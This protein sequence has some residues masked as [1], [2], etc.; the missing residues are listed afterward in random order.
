MVENLEE[1][2]DWDPS[3]LPFINHMIAGSLA[4]LAEHVTVFPIDTL[5]THVQCEVCGATDA[6]QVW[7]C[8]SRIVRH[9]GIFRLWRGVSAMFAACIPAHAAYFS[10]YESS[11]KLLMVNDPSIGPQHQPLRAALCGCFASISHDLFMTPFGKH[12]VYICEV[13]VAYDWIS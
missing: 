2:E 7:N 5:K 6:N 4:G 1:W 9:E 10:I 3:Q 13:F 8:A 11:K 12:F